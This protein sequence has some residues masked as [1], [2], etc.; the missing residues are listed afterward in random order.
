MMRSMFSGVSGLKAHQVRMDVIG[1]N[2]SNVNTVAYKSSKLSFS[3]IYS[4]TVKGA[5]GPQE[6]AG[7]TNPL[8]IGLGTTVGNVDV[9]HTK[10]SVQRTDNPTDIMIDGNGFFVISNDS[11]GENRF[12]SRAGNFT[13]DKLGYLV[14]PGGFK[15]LDR[16][17]KP[18]II[19]KAD[20]KG[21][22]ATGSSTPTTEINYKAGMILR[23]NVN[24]NEKDIYT[25]TA[26]V[27]D[28][29]GRTNN[30]NVSFL[31]TPVVS[32][33]S[34]A[35][36]QSDPRFDS[37]KAPAAQV[38]VNSF[39]TAREIQVK[40]SAGNNLLQTGSAGTL[41]TDHVYAVFNEKGDFCQL[42]HTPAA[43][44]LIGTAL[45]A[46]ALSA[47]Y[48]AFPA[49]TSN[50]K[51]TFTLN[52]P[53]A[54]PVTFD[55]S[56]ANFFE[57]GIET[58]GKQV[59]TQYAKE[60]DARTIVLDGNASGSLSSFTIGEDGLVQG[61]YTNGE[62]KLLASIALA[63]FDNP[64]GLMRMGANMFV[65]TVNSGAPRL[66]TPGRSGLGKLA[67]GA[68]EMSNVDLAG[69]FT[70]MITTQRGFQANSKIISSTDEMLSELANLK[71]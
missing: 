9:V 64:A 46:A 69:E 12:F 3:E 39:Y 21:A 44:P 33:A 23:N 5:S 42:L 36:A 4:Q 56:R 55:F 14:T 67:S 26:S 62:K 25:V 20:T 51:Y 58:K 11:K 15:V 45:S 35:L 43:T 50:V 31:Q 70:E 34:F 29:L 47:D 2:I 10:G 61:I 63:D 7:G 13:V 28:T 19:N 27:Y 54:A 60:S 48:T 65:D 18:V 37:T 8:Q 6:G 16:D 22:T 17:Y 40:D 24:Y 30:V 38:P 32:S 71:R 41:P 66:G 49:A 1:N 53:G 52:N 68:L 57:N 59:L